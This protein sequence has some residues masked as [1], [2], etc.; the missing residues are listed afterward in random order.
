LEFN[1]SLEFGILRWI[2]ANA[3]LPRPLRGHPFT[4]GE[5]LTLKLTSL[6]MLPRE[7]IP[8]S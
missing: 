3:E 6:T 1:W 8:L 4:A 5:L 2:P 7:L